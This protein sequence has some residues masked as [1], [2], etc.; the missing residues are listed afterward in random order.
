MAVTSYARINC[1]HAPPHTHHVL[2]PTQVKMRYTLVQSET[3]LSTGRA[4]ASRREPT[5]PGVNSMNGI[6][7]L[8]RRLVPLTAPVYRA[9]RP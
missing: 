4:R 8:V 3:H 6:R 5:S 2:R 7:A 9:V 1:V